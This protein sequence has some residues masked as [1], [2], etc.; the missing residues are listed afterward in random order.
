MGL[1]DSIKNFFRGKDKSDML[2]AAQEKLQDG[3]LDSVLNK[4]GIDGDKLGT[5]IEKVA[6]V[7]DSIENVVGG[8]GDDTSEEETEE[9]ATDDESEKE[10]A[11]TEEE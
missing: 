8:S 7:V 1:I 5:T 11:D 3:S 6:G 2:E 9:E 10:E 4:V